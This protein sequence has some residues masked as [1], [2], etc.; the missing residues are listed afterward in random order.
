M[1]INQ[2]QKCRILF[3]LTRP[4]FQLA[5]SFTGSGQFI[6][7]NFLYSLQDSAM[8]PNATRTPIMQLLLG[9]AMFTFQLKPC[10][11]TFHAL[12]KQKL[13]SVLKEE[14]IFN[15]T[16]DFSSWERLAFTDPLFDTEWNGPTFCPCVRIWSGGTIL[17]LS[18]LFW[19]MF[20]LLGIKT[21][22]FIMA[23]LVIFPLI[24]T[25]L[26]NINILLNCWEGK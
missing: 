20:R 12:V 8:W 22:S 18:Q 19:L 11:F 10:C 14:D 4:G 1:I 15:N 13:L 23:L 6:L 16:D 24:V 26:V 3:S 5:D 7:Q 25:I 2:G 21:S 17:T 9:G